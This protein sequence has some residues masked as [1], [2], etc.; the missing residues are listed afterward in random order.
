MTLWLCM[1][2][3]PPRYFTPDAVSR[4]SLNESHDPGAGADRRGVVV[5]A[6]GSLLAAKPRAMLVVARALAALRQTVVW[7]VV[8]ADVGHELWTEFDEVVNGM[9][10][11][12]D[13]AAVSISFLCPPLPLTAVVL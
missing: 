3:R 6:F 5:A 8:P 1:V 13:D 2:E 10:S 9:L 12:H 4:H 11:L 7:K